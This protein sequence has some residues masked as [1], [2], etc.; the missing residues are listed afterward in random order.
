MGDVAVNVNLIWHCWIYA[1]S[2]TLRYTNT[3]LSVFQCLWIYFFHPII[4]L[5]IRNMGSQSCKDCQNPMSSILEIDLFLHYGICW[6]HR[7]PSSCLTVS[8]PS[9]CKKLRANLEPF[10]FWNFPLWYLPCQILS[11]WFFISN[12]IVSKK[13]KRSL[14]SLNF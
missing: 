11:E 7:L 6:F 5:L 3:M 12:Q 14:L 9:C 1:F 13:S 2:P 10:K 4:P 8:A